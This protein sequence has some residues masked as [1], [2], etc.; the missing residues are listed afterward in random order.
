MSPNM[1]DRIFFPMESSLSWVT[2]DTW[3]SGREDTSDALEDVILGDSRRL[4]IVLR[5]QRFAA[6]FNTKV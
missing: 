2:G 5:G 3:G 4:E 6:I 1:K